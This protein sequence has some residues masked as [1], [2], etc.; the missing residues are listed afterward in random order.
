MGTM[1]VA[2]KASFMAISMSDSIAVDIFMATSVAL[3][4]PLATSCPR[5]TASYISLH[6]AQTLALCILPLTIART[7]LVTLALKKRWYV[8]MDLGGSST[9]MLFMSAAK[10]FSSFLEAIAEQM[11]IWKSSRTASGCRETSASNNEAKTS[12]RHLSRSRAS[13]KIHKYTY[14]YIIYIYII[15]NGGTST[16]THIY[17]LQQTTTKR[18]HIY[19][20]I[21]YLDIIYIY[22]ITYTYI[23]IYVGINV[24]CCIVPVCLCDIYENML[25]CKA[26]PLNLSL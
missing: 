22:M 14:I 21:Q 19:I 24:M 10:V 26:S 4:L 1:L 17:T 15:Y 8:F 5:T 7:H 2:G 23:Y 25:K 3:P 6:L 9:F 11:M 18:T 12:H 13:K 16:V 20:Y